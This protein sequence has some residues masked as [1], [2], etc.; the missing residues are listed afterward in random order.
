MLLPMSK[1][2]L[3]RE[4]NYF[5]KNKNIMHIVIV[6]DANPKTKSLF[7]YEKK[8]LDA[9]KSVSPSSTV[10]IVEKHSARLNAVMPDAEILILESINQE[11]LRRA[12]KLRWIHATA[13]GVASLVETLNSRPVLLTN[14]SGVHPVPIAEH[15]FTFLLTFARNM[16]RMYRAG[17]EK[18]WN[19]DAEQY[20]I[21]ELH[22]KTIGIVGYGRIGE[23]IAKLSRAFDMKVLAYASTKKSSPHIDQS[24]VKSELITLLQ[25]SDFVVN[26]LPLTKQT[27]GMFDYSLFKHMKKSAYFINIGR[28]QTVVETA[29]VK[30]LKNKTI[31]GAALDVFSEE[32]LPE[33]SPLWK[34]ENVIITPHTAGWTPYYIDRMI[35]IFCQNLSAYLSDKPLPTLVDKKR[36]Y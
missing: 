23:E 12:K 2:I 33:K 4:C 31:A 28:G 20:P 17:L 11:E 1:W 26:C 22:G 18:R 27:Q 21:F 14:S 15:V 9:I 13:A 19:R 36:G 6:S 34:M 5:E 30:A 3:V 29:M 24:Y 32:P 16:H 25:Q 7:R 35:D 8:H 10:T